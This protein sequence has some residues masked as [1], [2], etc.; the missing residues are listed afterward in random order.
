MSN[1]NDLTKQKKPIK[2]IVLTIVLGLLFVLAVAL[3]SIAIWYRNNYHMEFGAL[4]MVLGGPIEGTGDN[5]INDI[6]WAVLPS[7]IIALVIYVGV[8]LIVNFEYINIKKYDK[9]KTYNI[10][11]RVGSL[12]CVCT[13]LFSMGY[14]VYA[15]KMVTWLRNIG[16]TTT[17]FEDHYVDPTDVAIT[18]NGDTKNVIYIYLE[19]METTH[20]SVE[21]GGMLDKNYIP[22]LTA[23]ARENTSFSQYSDKSK[24]G[25]FYALEGSSWTIAGILSSTGGIP[26]KFEVGNN[27]MD[28]AKTFAP[29]LTTFGDVLAEKGYHNY[30][31]CGS[32]AV[33]GG[34][35]S[36]F[37]SHGNYTI[38]DLYSS[39]AEGYIPANYHD[40]WWGFEDYHLYNIAK[41]KLTKI[42]T[43]EATKDEPFNFT[44]LTVDTHPKK[45]HGCKLC[46]NKNLTENVLPCADNQIIDFVNW[47][48]E[49]PFYEDTVIIV[50]GDHLRSDNSLIEDIEFHDRR[51]YNCIINSD[52]VPADGAT[53]N[54]A[55]C[56][57]DLFPTVLSA[58][59]FD[60]EGDRLGLGTNLYSGKQTLIEELGFDYFDNELKKSSDFYTKRWIFNIDED[61]QPSKDQ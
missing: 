30:F 24:L 14:T 13:L 43:D 53:L 35:Q 19:S 6:L 27:N 8:A 17:V 15:F 57:F 33:F 4:L 42:T 7:S 41:S 44:M 11:R 52:R 3:I 5:M 60:V 48:K 20:A 9:P 50:V 47:C 22:G 2:R 59:N 21:D 23:L 58:M 18:A 1:S 36:Y 31:L 34:R 26:Y 32:D 46:G 16:E 40:G 25:G 45:G 61:L 56:T 51:V 28:D 54:R 39:S 12:L 38:F 37:S 29:L 49:Q 55:W 10:I